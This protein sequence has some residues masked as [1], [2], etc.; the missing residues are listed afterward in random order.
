VEA[1]ERQVRGR[2]DQQRDD[3]PKVCP[4]MTTTTIARRASAPGQ[5]PTASGSMPPTSAGVLTLLSVKPNAHTTVN[6]E[7]TDVGIAT[8]AMKADR[9]IRMKS[10]TTSVA[11]IE[12]RLVYLNL[13]Q[14]G[15]DIARLAADHFERHTRGQQL[16]QPVKLRAHALDDG[17]AVR[18]RLSADLERDG[19]H[20]VQP[21]GNRP[22]EFR[23]AD[24][25]IEHKGEKRQ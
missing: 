22:I 8:P 20:P 3:Q 17:D 12:P 25:A 13:V 1:V 6:V 7:T 15:V 18:A 10:S 16:A 11:R 24:Q 14:G 9:H 5:V 19:G 21:G 2:R 23:Y 4:P